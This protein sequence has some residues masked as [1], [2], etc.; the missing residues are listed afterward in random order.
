MRGTH[1]DAGSL[2][3]PL[4]GVHLGEVIAYEFELPAR[5]E[6]RPGRTRLER[7]FVLLDVGVSFA[8]PCWVRTANPDGSVLQV[9]PTGTDS[10]YV[11]LV[12]VDV[13]GDRY[14]FR[15]LYIDVIIP[16][17]GRHHRM[18]DLD[19]YADAMADGTL[20]LEDG[21]DGLRRWQRFW[22]AIFMPIAGRKRTGPIFRRRQF[23]VCSNCRRHWQIQCGGRAR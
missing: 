18:L 16:T 12:T 21:I 14:T 9:D 19:E 5:F 17:D 20:S 15:D 7:T 1:G 2:F 3:G 6:P 4:P 23:A 22:I 13:Q 11:D 8:N 10:W